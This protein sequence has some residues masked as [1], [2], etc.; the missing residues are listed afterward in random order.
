ML[1]QYKQSI[2]GILFILC[3]F[4]MPL[5]LHAQLNIKAARALL[6]RVVPEH[7]GHFEVEPLPGNQDQDL[8]EIES[9]EDTIVLRGTNGV[10]VASALH[11]YLKHFCQTEVSWSNPHP[12][13]P[14]TLPPVPEKVRKSSPYI[15]RYYLNYV[16][17]N[18]TM[19]WWDW[20][21]WEQ[22]LDW[23]ALHG[24]N[25]PLAVLGQ[26]A[27][28]QRVYKNMGFTDEELEEF[29][30]GPAYT[31]FN[32]MGLL[33]GWGGPMPQRWID[34][35]EKLQQKILKRARSLGMTPV[36]PAFTGHVPPAFKEKFPDAQLQQ[37]QWTVFPEV[38]I[39]APEDP[40]FVEIGIK[41]INELRRTYGTDHLYS[42]DT[43]IEVLP[44]SDDPDYLQDMSQMIYGSMAAADPE[45]V[46]VMQGWMFYFKEEFWQPLQIKALLNAVPDDNM[47]VL[48]LWT[49]NRP[50]WN[51]TEAYYGKPWLWCMVHNFGG[52]HSLFGKMPTI[53]SHPARDWQ[54]PA[55][56]RMAG[57][58][59]TM[60]ALEQN[61]AV[62]AL[63]L[64]NVWRDDSIDL[65]T[66]LDGYLQR[67]Y[68]QR[69]E[70]ARKAWEILKSTV[71]GYEGNLNTGGPRSLITTVPSLDK[72]PERRAVGSYYNPGDLLPAWGYMIEA[73]ED[74]S[75]NASFRYD[76]VD[77]GRQ[78]LA[79]YANYLQQAYATAYKQGK[80][81]EY[82][83]YRKRFIDLIDDLD[84]LVGTQEEFLL[85]RWIADARSW[86]TTQSEKDLYERNARN[87]ITLWHGKE[88]TNL[89]DYARRQWSGMLKGFYK[90]RW[91]QF[92]NYAHE[93][94]EERI[95]MNMDEFE[96]ELRNWEWEWIQ[97]RASYPATPEGDPIAIT[98]ELYKKYRS[99][100][101]EA[102][103]IELP[104]YHR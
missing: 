24:I 93:C 57:L 66:W 98:R 2:A 70:A 49:E 11:Y 103:S 42:A 20:E 67:R 39:L 15:Y 75:Q 16:T 38:D 64:E 61:P 56:G 65:D 19:V 5:Q 91:E 82:K 46:W 72:L 30:S 87:L 77:I 6:Q 78:V 69:N 74:L 85:G 59:L 8:F 45:A 92:F 71:Y 9:R 21:R 32:W 96:E 99:L 76:L 97:K 23:M 14:E 1:T 54:D 18:Y 26:N 12:E 34:S 27:V 31:A 41:F 25:M 73:A 48:D 50:V 88:H 40:M 101:A 84:R 81:S 90:P 3:I 7:H 13:L 33:D 80:T 4:I 62:Y 29:F 43:F 102:Y 104:F 28:W 79:N 37:V 94:K 52:N 51:R 47:I 22:E 60:E 58:G 63:F 86:G 35:H 36:L 95:A 100:L 53:A 68:G 55:S 17:Y 44:P 83:R 10:S 89:Q